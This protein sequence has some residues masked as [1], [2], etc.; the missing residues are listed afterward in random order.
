MNK[1]NRIFCVIVAML[2]AL[3]VIEISPLVQNPLV[4]EVYAGRVNVTV[5]SS[6]ANHTN[7]STG[8]ITFFCNASVND[9]AN[10]SNVSLYIFANETGGS[11]SLY[12]SATNT[13]NG[14]NG[15][16]VIRNWTVT[17]IPELFGFNYTWFCN[18]TDNQSVSNRSYTNNSFR[19]DTTPPRVS[20]I[21]P[22]DNSQYYQFNS[23]D[24]VFNASDNSSEIFNCTLFIEDGERSTDTSVTLDATT[25]FA[26]ITNIN[27]TDDTEWK[28]ACYD[29]TRNQ[30][31][32]TV[33]TFNSKSPT[34]LSG[35]GSNIIGTTT[36][37]SGSVITTIGTGTNSFFQSIGNFINNLIQAIKGIFTKG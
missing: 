17:G 21:N 11:W 9:T 20:L 23:L 32:S 33:Y 10:I 15:T 12:Y 3:L 6:P 25:T 24:F 28:V 26:T 34:G 14:S 36:T 27:I 19:V 1:K 35:G 8:D 7:S 29:I 31:N 4:K 30:G 16:V 37:D 13:T 22:I 5:W 18:A 2:F